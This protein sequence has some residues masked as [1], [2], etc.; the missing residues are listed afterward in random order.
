MDNPEF[1]Q[2]V[3]WFRHSSP[4]INQHR[5]CTFVLH[6]SGSAVA[7]HDFTHLIHD[8]ALLSSLGVRL[9]LVPGA[10]H[11][12]EQLLDA[13]S[14]PTQVVDH[15]RITDK[16]TLG[17]VQ[18]AVG[19]LRLDIE[20]QLSMGLPN[21]PMAG[22]RIRVVSGNFVVAKP[23]GVIKGIDYQYTG[24]V[25]RVEKHAIK[26]LL[27]AGNIVLLPPLGFSPSG[28][29]FNVPAEHIASAVAS[30]LH[31][32]KLIYMLEQPVIHDH[33]QQPLSVLGP[34]QA[35]QLLTDQNLN[36]SHK[37]ALSACLQACEQGVRRAHIIN[38]QQDGALL[39]ELFTRDGQG[40]L[41][42]TD[43]YEQLRRADNDD[44]AGLLELIIPLEAQG[45][46]I[47]RSPDHIERD[48]QYFTVIERDGLII[49]CAAL[50]PYPA[51]QVAELAC[52]AIHPHY[53]GGQ[54]GDLLLSHAEKHAQQQGLNQ[55]I[56]LTTQSTHWFLERGFVKTEQSAL[57]ATRRHNYNTDRN[58]QILCKPLHSSPQ[59]TGERLK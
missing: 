29:L 37:N 59:R 25:R 24:T 19:R 15:L 5:G 39:I 27:A 17:Y 9:V 50:Y 46:L 44:I 6:F 14:H 35:Q 11:Q 42:T 18:E 45:V 36:P 21:S 16:R 26:D 32:D 55:L 56:V 34:R 49:G 1:A 53:T 13:A 43:S 2:Y 4:Y 54:Y 30:A 28:E 31:A 58:S 41:I 40:N 47:H 12:I 33:Q 20:S 48:I 3:Q 8:I 51:E 38:R 22:A 10:R 23:I 7:S 57:P 52:V